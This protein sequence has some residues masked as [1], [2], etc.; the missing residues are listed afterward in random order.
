[1]QLY[2]TPDAAKRLSL[3]ES[4]LEKMRCAGNGPAFVRLG[5]AVAYRESDLE[6]WVA[7]NTCRNTSEIAEA[8]AR[9]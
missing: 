3:S 4:S 8:A 6:A 2:R 5:R 7:A 9:G 1:M